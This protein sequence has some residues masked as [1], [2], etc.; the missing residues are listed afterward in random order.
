MAVVGLLVTAAV[1]ST[2]S[3]LRQAT[4]TLRN[5]SRLLKAS[6][7]KHLG[8]LFFSKTEKRIRAAEVEVS[9]LWQEQLGSL[10]LASFR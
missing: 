3:A 2:Q 7:Q 9:H 4:R 5:I 8:V 10:V 6:K 1:I